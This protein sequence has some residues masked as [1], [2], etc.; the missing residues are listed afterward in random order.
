MGSSQNYRSVLQAELHKKNKFDQEIPQL[1]INSWHIGARSAVGNV[2]GNRCQS[3]C[4]SR[5]R[6]FDPG[7]VLYFLGDWS[8]NSS[9]VIL[10]PYA[11]SF[12]KCCCQLQAKV[13]A[14]STG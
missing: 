9:M 6:K 11:E 1:Q 5:G 3:D 8:W 14:Q 2:S 10:L 13:S 4:I 12:K 7:P